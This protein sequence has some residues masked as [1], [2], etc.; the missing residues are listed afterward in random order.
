MVET[1]KGDSSILNSAGAYGSVHST[2]KNPLARE[3]M[4]TY[5]LNPT[6][7]KRVFHQPGASL[8]IRMQTHQCQCWG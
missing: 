8:T 6:G 2:A 5:S 3:D 4:F 7:K 1:G